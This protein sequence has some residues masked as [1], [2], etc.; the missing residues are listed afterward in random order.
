MYALAVAHTQYM[1]THCTY[2]YDCKSSMVLGSSVN[3]FASVFG[4]SG[5]SFPPARWAGVSESIW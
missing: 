1:F 4:A 2:T 3:C 5:H